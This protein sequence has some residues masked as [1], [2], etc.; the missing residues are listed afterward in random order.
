MLER[1]KGEEGRRQATREGVGGEGEGEEGAEWEESGEVEF[2]REVEGGEGDGEDRAGGGAG[3][4][5]EGGGAGARG[6]AS[7]GGWGGRCGPGGEESRRVGVDA[8]LELEKGTEL[9]G[10]LGGGGGDGEKE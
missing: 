10:G 4:A 3:D 9:V 2:A 7:G 6:G 8:L 5:V 1:W